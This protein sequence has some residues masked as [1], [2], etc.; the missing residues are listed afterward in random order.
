[1]SVLTLTCGHLVLVLLKSKQ[2][3]KTKNKHKIKY[4]IIITILRN[5]IYVH[6]IYYVT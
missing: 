4:I 5:I 6:L 2:T 3:K 1:M